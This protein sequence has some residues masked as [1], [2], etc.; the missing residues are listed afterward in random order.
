MKNYCEVHWGVW[1]EGT[2]EWKMG[3]ERTYYAQ[4]HDPRYLPDA[5]RCDETIAEWE[6]WH[7]E[8]KTPEYA[9]YVARRL[10][11]G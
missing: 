10:L 3:S 6:A 7:R 9:R 1:N 11:D 5:A 2:G 8:H 4:V